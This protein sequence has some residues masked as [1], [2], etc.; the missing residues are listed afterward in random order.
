MKVSE[1]EAIMEAEFTKLLKQAEEPPRAEPGDY[2]DPVS[3]LL[4]CGKCRTAKQHRIHLFGKEYVVTCVCQCEHERREAEREAQRR[5]EQL[6]AINRM[7]AA[8]LQDKALKNYTFANDIGDNPNMPKAKN[9]VKHWKEMYSEN[10]GLFLYG[11]VGTG[12]SFFAGCIAN[13]L[14]EQG[15]PVLMTNFS[16]VLN[17]L[18]R[19]F[20]EDRN[21]YIE[22]LNKYHLLIIDD[23]GIE[24]NTEYAMEQVFGVIDGRYRSGKPMIIT[25]NLSW[26]DITHPRD[27]MHVRIYDRI[28]EVCQPIAFTGR[29]YRSENAEN[30]RRKT[31]QLLSTERRE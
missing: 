29:N 22:S 26:F 15:V 19:M 14:I 4:Y 12:K 21:A 8:G 3:H 5:K 13:A 23:L 18:T 6:I 30:K 7:K 17:S 16:K 27:L 28:R 24:R 31:V 1:S 10:I 9:Y 20:E 25:T 2:I 11:N